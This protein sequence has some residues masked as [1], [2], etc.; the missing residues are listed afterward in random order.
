M[1]IISQSAPVG[2]LFSSDQTELFKE[3]AFYKSACKVWSLVGAEQMFHGTDE[4]AVARL[5]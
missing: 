3:I 2:Q 1:R 5:Q 4:W